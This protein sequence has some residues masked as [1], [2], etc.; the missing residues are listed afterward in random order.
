MVIKVIGNCCN[1]CYAT[2]Q[3]VKSAAASID[4]NIEVI[5]IDDILQILQLGIINTPAVIINDEIVSTGEHL[6]EEEA[7]KIILQHK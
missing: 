1:A 5:H 6:S 2:Y 7:L 4:S 3:A